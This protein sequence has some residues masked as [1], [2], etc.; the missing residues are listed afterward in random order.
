M[1]MLLRPEYLNGPFGDPA[2]YIWEMNERDALLVDCGDLSRFTPRQLLKVKYL[3]ISH[4]HMDHF[5][6]F[7]AFLRVHMG[8]DKSIQ[9]Y[10][11]PETSHR[12]GGK[13][14]GYTWNLVHE[15]D[16]E[17]VVVDLDPQN[18]I[19]TETRFHSRN[20]F[21]PEIGGSRKWDPSEPILNGHTYQVKTTDLD[22]R[23]S[24]M[25]YSIE[26]KVTVKLNFSMLDELKIKPDPWI[27]TLKTLF[28]SGKLENQWLDVPLLQGGQEKMNA[29]E[30]AEKVLIP[31]QRH[32]IV[33]ATDGAAHPKNR[34]KLLQFVENADLWF[35][36]TCFLKEDQALA[37]ATQHFTA[38]FIGALAHE[39][40]VKVLAPFHFS[41]R[42]LNCPMKVLHEV[43]ESF[44]GPVVN[45][46][47]KV[48]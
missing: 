14:Q 29:N 5:F 32:K 6:G 22:H 10:G 34:I 24:S 21:L 2:L 4:C 41:K 12:V 18:Q 3:F 7:D 17:F 11:P 26:E 31:R 16:L 35:S 9:I 47:K 39:A 45:L 43:N 19:Q 28:L 36:E 20:R 33:Y 46:G 15:Q 38:E 23:T 25:A 44:Q 40:K 8:M 42:Y 13:L 30:L 48:A 1:R 37:E 27:G